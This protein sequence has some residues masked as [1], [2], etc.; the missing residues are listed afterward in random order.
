MAR[1]IINIIS[2][3][4]KLIEN[5]KIG[6]NLMIFLVIIIYYLVKND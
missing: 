3:I 6:K 4:M 1:I 5:I 2:S